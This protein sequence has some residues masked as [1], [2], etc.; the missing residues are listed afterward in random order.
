MNLK[1]CTIRVVDFET[2]GF[3]ADQDKICEV[4]WCDVSYTDDKWQSGMPRYSLINPGI[5]IPVIS[6]A[7]H[8]ITDNDV[9]DALPE[10]KV[11]PKVFSKNIPLFCAHNAEF[12][13][14]FAKTAG[15]DARWLC[16]YRLALHRIPD[17]PS[18]KNQ[19]LRYYLGFH[20]IGGDAHRAGH[21]AAVTARI[22][23]HILN[24][25][26][27]E[28]TIDSIIA[29]A[30]TPVYLRGTMGFGKHKDKTW[31]ECPLQ[32]LQWMRKQG[33]Q[34]EG[35]PDGWNRDQWFTLNKVLQS[36]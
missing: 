25:S 6:M 5:K 30:K 1:E 13:G 14:A 2:T 28:H 35:N 7:V 24:G 20:S 34:S 21:D 33:E 8:H 17:A 26:K 18:Y 10:D 3:D 9:A 27:F 15:H 31:S 11:L 19:V 16:T 36:E 4:G 12:D 22:L 29:Y 23:C 32:Y